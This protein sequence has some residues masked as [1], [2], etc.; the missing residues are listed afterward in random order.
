MNRPERSFLIG[1]A[2][3]CDIVL[4]DASVSRRHA[5]LVYTP[6]GQWLLVDRRS[7]NGTSVGA[8]DRLRRISQ[9]II[10]PADTV[11]FGNLTMPASELLRSV[12]AK[13]PAPLPAPAPVGQGR[14]GAPPAPAAPAGKPWVRATRLV[15]CSCGAV[16]R[17]GGT[18]P[19]CN[20]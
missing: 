18:C 14:A 12:Q 8:G 5:E 19:E 1:R 9:E 7:Q 2:T 13:L 17:K 20:E 10:T 16:K 4:A 15:R 3:E 11:R 6:Q